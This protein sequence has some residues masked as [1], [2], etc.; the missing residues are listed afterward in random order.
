ML[1]AR[2]GRTPGMHEHIIHMLLVSFALT[3]TCTPML[4]GIYIY[5]FRLA[6]ESWQ[7]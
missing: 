2:S 4:G 1:T 5:T 7:R 6:P 3:V